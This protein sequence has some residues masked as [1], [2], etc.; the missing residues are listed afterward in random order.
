[1]CTECYVYAHSPFLYVV[2]TATASPQNISIRLDL[3]SIRQG[4]E[5]RWGRAR[6][7]KLGK[8]GG[9]FWKGFGKLGQIWVG[10]GF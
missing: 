3:E 7:R 9:V 6:V 2:L 10:Q 8:E 5:R 1:L 4:W